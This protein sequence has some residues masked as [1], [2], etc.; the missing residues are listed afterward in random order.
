MPLTLRP[1]RRV[2]RSLITLTAAALT[3]T[4]APA[5][6]S[7][8]GPAGSA[9]DS[10][11]SLIRTDQGLVRGESTA[12][13][14]QFLGIPYAAKPTGDLRWQ[15]PH[16]PANWR[17]VRD[18][19]RYGD[20]CAQNTYWAPGY[21]T[22]HTTEDCLDVNVYT[23]STAARASRLPVLVW[24]HG[25]GNIGGAARDIVPD[26]FARRTNAVV[27]T[28]N[29]RLGAL[30]FL[31][32]PGTTGN[33]A[34]LDQQQALRWV[35]SNIAAFGG[36]PRQVT[37]AG[38]SAGGGAVCTQLASP[39]SRG[40][41]R[42]AIIQSGAY[43]DCAGIPREKA[44]AN[45]L[46]FAKKLGCTVA[47]TAADCLRAK[48]AKAILDAQ[49]GTFLETW[50]YTVG[51]RALPLQPAQAFTSGRAS[52]VPVLNGAN[53]DEGLVFSYDSFDRWGNPL[54]ADAYPKA[55]TSAFGDATGAKALARYPL[56]TYPRPG[57]AYAAAFGDQLFAC[58]A[59]RTSERLANRGQ[60]YAY[61]FADRT[62]PLFAS[63]PQNADFDF[64]ATH[65]AELNYLFKPYGIS[66]RLNAEQRTL[67]DQMTA[68]WG[69]F[70]HGSA[71]SAPGQPAMPDQT[72]TPGE[73]L[74]LRT[75][76]QS[77]NTATSDTEAA[78]KCD[79]WDAA[80][81]P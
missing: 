33:F 2:R 57:Y 64:G 26:T 38:E 68:Y 80:A 12:G 48:P 72:S 63:L 79:L 31:T 40:L 62:S 55:L 56:S 41:Y 28:V 61:E 5:L 73:V 25:G 60:V 46:A 77:G 10:E 74:Q 37:L 7:P 42:A 65:A 35:Q 13:G 32:L 52:H 67:A 44:V 21:A 4:C 23:P 19:T 27:V 22:Q 50:N 20:Y 71:P 39:T 36:D 58:P 6:A 30:G 1:W 81:T 17:G 53:S 75:A 18:A 51:G 59:L 16:R 11:R 66:A 8:P 76:S 78:H 54:T 29:Y 3:L 45:G 47:A 70:I 15:A 34:L 9:A 43:F 49:N 24:I 69:S 14:R